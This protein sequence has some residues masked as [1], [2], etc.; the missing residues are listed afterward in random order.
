MVSG[1]H[2]IAVLSQSSSAARLHHDEGPLR[3]RAPGRRAVGRGAR[4]GYRGLC[5]Q[6]RPGGVH[7]D[8]GVRL[9]GRGLQ[10]PPP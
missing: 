9:Q 8:R 4:R 3:G 7:Q 1:R 5:W 10:M 6:C 2:L